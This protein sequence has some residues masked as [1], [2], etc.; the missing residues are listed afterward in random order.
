MSSKSLLA[1][2]YSRNHLSGSASSFISTKIIAIYSV[3]RYALSPSCPGHDQRQPPID[4]AIQARIITFWASFTAAN[5]RW[6]FGM[7]H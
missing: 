5:R 2:A 1:D 6:A 7:A 3:N 4:W